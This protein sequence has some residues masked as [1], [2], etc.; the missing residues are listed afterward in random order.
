M[1]AF[2]T[3]RLLIAD[4]HQLVRDGLRMTLDGA[5][6]QIVAEA[7]DGQQAF[8]E[9]QRHGADVALID[10]SMPRADGFRFLE[11]V[12]EAGSIVSILMHSVHDGSEYF[13]RCR[14]LGAKGFLLKGQDRDV[15][16][17]AIRTVHA[18]EEFWH[19]PSSH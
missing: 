16:L 11:L 3:I 14:S 9:L 4:D 8:D 12:Q 1:D 17:N 5:E 18:G 6:V 2:V 19:G 15:L 10:I 7:A 13:R